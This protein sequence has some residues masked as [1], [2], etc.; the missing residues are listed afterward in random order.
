MA[1]PTSPSRPSVGRLILVPS[2][3]TLAITVLRLVG[4]L[5][6]WS[7]KLFNTSVGGAGALIGISWLPIFFGPYFAAR[8]L[9]AGERPKSAG[10][11]IGVAVLGVGVAI[12]LI[13]L[14]Q[15]LRM[16]FEFE[17]RLLYGWTVFVV[18]A[19]VAF[20]AWRALFK[21]LLVYAY[22]ARIPIAAIMFFAFQGNWGTHYDAPP[23][24]LPPTMSLVP[25]YIWLGFV[26]QL[27]FWVAFTLMVGMFFGTL[28]AGVMRFA[29]G[30]P[31]AAGPAS[32]PN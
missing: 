13:I 14:P 5:H 23:P 27:T 19:L 32:K 20:A 6:H 4:E 25:K 12:V 9:K 17:P 29:R 26:P 18:G 21:V 2:I 7:P 30:A 15:W 31:E 28:A 11:A 22:A 24:D 3:I 1:E 16:R 10:L 8:L